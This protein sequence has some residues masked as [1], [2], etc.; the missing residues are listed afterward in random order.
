M[1]NVGCGVGICIFSSQCF[2]VILAVTICQSLVDCLLLI[3]KLGTQNWPRDI[4]MVVRRISAVEAFH[5]PVV[6]PQLRES[7]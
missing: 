2:A 3:Q 1:D 4:A 6:D 7:D 5:N